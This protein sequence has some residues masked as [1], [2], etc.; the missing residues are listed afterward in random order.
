MLRDANTGENRAV[1]ENEVWLG[2]AYDEWYFERKHGYSKKEYAIQRYYLSM[3]VWANQHAYYDLLNG[4]NRTALDVGC[5]YGFV[6]RLLRVLGYE[7]LGVDVS[8]YAITRGKEFGGD[9]LLVS[10]A[11]HLP[12]KASSFD[13]ITCFESLEHLPKANLALSHIY[14]L[15]KPG[16][17]L[18]LT[19]PNVSM[20]ATIII[21]VLSREPVFTHPSVKPLN[22]WI[23]ILSNLGFSEIKFE[24]FLLLPIPPT[25]FKRYFV[26]KC[27]SHFSSHVRILA[28]KLPVGGKS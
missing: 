3:I 27:S 22:E 10:D 19:T 23:E 14:E 16:G 13:L 5:A 25:L 17:V 12:F 7:A 20:V 15:L 21:N 8:K 26:V 6:V 9:G 24:P 4:C 2:H 28:T 1:H 18:I 11:Q